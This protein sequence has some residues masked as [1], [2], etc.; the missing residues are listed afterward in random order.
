MTPK[1]KIKTF[2][3]VSKTSPGDKA[4]FARV[5]MSGIAAFVVSSAL[6]MASV[7]AEAQRARNS[8]SQQSQP[9][10]GRQFSA[11]AG[12]VVNEALQ[13]MNS[14]NNAAAIST[15]QRAIA[16]PDLNAYEK[17]TIYQMMG[18]AYYETNQ[19][20]QAISSF[21]KAISAGGL[22]PNERNKLR[23]NIALLLIANNQPARGA[24]MLEE[25]GRTNTLTPKHITYIWQAWVQAENYSRALPW[26]EKWFRAASPKERTHF[27]TLNF[28]YNRLNMPGKQADIVKQMINRWP[29]DKTLWDTWASMLANGGREQESFEVTK[30]LYL[31][32]ALTSQQD[33]E[34]VVQYYSFYDMPYQAAQILEKEMRAGRIRESADK[35]VQLSDL[36]RQAREYKKAIPVLER[37]AASSGKAKLYADLGEALFN[38]GQCDKAEAAFKKAMDRGYDK[39]KSLMLIANCRFDQAAKEERPKCLPDGS[40]EPNTQWEKKREIALAA[41]ERVPPSSGEARNAR[42][43][44]SYIKSEKKSLKNRCVFEKDLKRQKCYGMIARAKKAEFLDGK[45]Q[46]DDPACKQFIP[47]WEKEFLQKVEK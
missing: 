33:L 32:G 25:W 27:D 45:F 6:F 20:S 16:L 9:T 19:P 11:K 41:F 40:F 38:E 5:L 12:E 22:L 34:K 13:Q 24:Q 23:E 30:M 2:G 44:I 15:L 8:S 47:A 1:N 35:L 21:E 43:W 46:L 31:G 14:N 4:S 28:L 26:A 29:Q 10:E 3:K 17:S 7:N 37:A 18:S 39:G 42:K 36:Y